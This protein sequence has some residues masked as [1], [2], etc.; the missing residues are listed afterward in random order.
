MTVRVPDYFLKFKCIADRCTDNCC[1]GWEIDIDSKTQ[2]K[3]SSLDGNLGEEIREKT[4]HG[5]FP[6][7]KN[8]RCAF[9]DD[10][11]LC[12][13]I[14][15][16]GDGYLCDICKEHPRYY[17]VGYGCLEGGIGLA[18]PEA[19]RIILSI[20]EKPKFLYTEAT[21]TYESEDEFAA[22]CDRLRELTYEAIYKSRADEL[23]SEIL[24]I[25]RYADELAFCLTSGIEAPGF[26]E[27][28]SPDADTEKLIELSFDAFFD[29]EIMSDEWSARFGRARGAV[30][31]DS[32]TKSIEE[33]APSFRA[34]LFYFTHRYIRECISDMTAGAKVVF[35]LLSS[36]LIFAIADTYESDP[37]EKAAVL[38]SKNIE[39]STEN[40]DAAVEKICEFL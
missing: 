36:I 4:Q 20:K 23:L 37:L 15:S 1:I 27:V 11:G 35:S 22:E 14:S 39:Y 6:L 40:I 7:Q 32:L 33:N 13:I 12:R 16:L 29:S 24:H 5:Y 19:A 30:T 28:E 18:C 21:P 31:K 17:G 34:L 8:G 10:R 26:D 38:F 9:L 2:A 3:Y 25:A